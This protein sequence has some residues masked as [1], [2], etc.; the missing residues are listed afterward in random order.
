VASNCQGETTE[1]VSPTWVLFYESSDEYGP[2]MATYAINPS[3]DFNNVPT[4][5]WVIYRDLT[6]ITITAA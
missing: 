4:T 3:Q 5:G 6:T 2:Y 1:A